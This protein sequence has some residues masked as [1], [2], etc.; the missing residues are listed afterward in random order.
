M[1]RGKWSLG[2]T[3]ETSEAVARQAESLRAYCAS[4]CSVFRTEEF[5]Q[6]DAKAK[7]HLW[8]SPN[9][10]YR[11]AENI[12]KRSLGLKKAHNDPNSGFNASHY[13]SR[14]TI[15]AQIKPNKTEMMLSYILR[16]LAPKEFRYNGDGRLGL[17]FGGIAPDFVNINGKKQVIEIYCVYYKEKNHG[18]VESY[19]RLRTNRLAKLGYKVLFIEEKELRDKTKLKQKVL[20]FTNS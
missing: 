19:K 3:K 16:H 1:Q 11:T 18:S 13:I 7:R 8:N 5:K 6:K 12:E 10:V 15:G 20:E 4:P 2:L 9:S 17:E 14:L